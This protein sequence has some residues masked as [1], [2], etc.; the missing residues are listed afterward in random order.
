MSELLQRLG[1]VIGISL[2]LTVLLMVL[3]QDDTSAQF[4]DDP[5]GVTQAATVTASGHGTP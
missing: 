5:A 1:V 2:V 3:Y 4:Q